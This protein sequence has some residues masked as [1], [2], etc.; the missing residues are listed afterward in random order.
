VDKFKIQGVD[1][2]PIGTLELSNEVTRAIE[3]YPESISLTPLWVI[4]EGRN[5]LVG[6]QVTVTPAIEA[7]AIRVPDFVGPHYVE[8]MTGHIEQL[9]LVGAIYDTGRR[10]I[11]LHEVNG[12]VYNYENI[13]STKK[14]NR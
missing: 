8:L 2:L 14:R 11:Y 12:A 4:Q 6:W 1:G 9:D 13:I 5:R 3:Q 7:S 10:P